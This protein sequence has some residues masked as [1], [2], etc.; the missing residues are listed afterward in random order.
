LAARETHQADDSTANRMLKNDAMKAAGKEMQEFARYNIRF[1][2]PMTAEQKLYYGVLTADQKPTP[3]PAPQTF[4][5]AEADLLLPALGIG[6]EP[7][8]AL[9]GILLGDYSVTEKNKDMEADHEYSAA[10]QVCFFRGGG[11]PGGGAVFF[12]RADGGAGRTGSGG[13]PDAYL[14]RGGERSQRGGRFYGY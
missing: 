4:P 8:R 14:Y 11:C 3:I 1:N 6:L 7:E 2:R 9:R 12:M 5:E 13:P 10:R